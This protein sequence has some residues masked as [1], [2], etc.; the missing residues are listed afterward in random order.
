LPDIYK[1]ISQTALTSVTRNFEFDSASLVT[2]ISFDAAAGQVYSLA[3][4]SLSGSSGEFSFNLV[5]LPAP[6]N[7][8]FLERR[9]IS[10]TSISMTAVNSAAT[11]EPGEPIHAGNEGGKSVWFGWKAP[12][13]GTI[14]VTVAA[15]NFFPLVDAYSGV[16]LSALT[17]APRRMISFD[18]N[19]NSATV[20]FDAMSDQEYAIVVDGFAGEFGSFTLTL[21]IPP[22][23]ANDDFAHRTPLTGSLVRVQ[24][25]NLYA[26]RENAE[27]LHAGQAGGKSIWYS[28]VAPVSGPVI[29]TSR[30]N[31]FFTLPDI[32]TGESLDELTSVPRRT[33]KFEQTNFVSTLNFTAVA[34]QSYAL[35][36]DGF[37]GRSGLIDLDLATLNFPPTVQLLSIPPLT[38]INLKLNLQGSRG[39]S[40]AIQVSTNLADWIDL[41]TGTFATNSFSYVDENSPNF[42]Y[43]F[44]RVLPLP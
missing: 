26:T 23:P 7:D 44:Y 39:Q 19:N 14:I 22:P 16:A 2:R 40:F 3:I 24:T 25:S 34:F 41:F 18:Q 31:S 27:P 12:S 33:L 43:R 10:G 29:V 38:P 20:T 17:N 8:N 5:Y 11:A 9:I 42:S 35:A 32:Y 37:T 6:E 36:I 15:T 13:S 21:S 1:P 4:D 30:G 28:W